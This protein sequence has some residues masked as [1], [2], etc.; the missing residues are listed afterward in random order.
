MNTDWGKLQFGS[1]RGKSKTRG[2]S[3]VE[4]SCGAV[5]TQQCMGGRVFGG[6]SHIGDL[7]RNSS[8]GGRGR[9]ITR[10]QNPF[11]LWL[12]MPLEPL[13]WYSR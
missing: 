9:P 6:D 13:C 8:E 5:I 3:E 12:W 10:G 4:V 7:Q 2:A 11:S 1:W